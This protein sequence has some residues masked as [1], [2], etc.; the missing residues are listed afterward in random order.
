VA[1]ILIPAV[2][3]GA[4]SLIL[5][6]QIYP[7]VK[8]RARQITGYYN[9]TRAE[10]IKGDSIQQ[11]EV[12]LSNPGSDYFKKLTE[13]A[14]SENILQSDSISKNYRGKFNL[15]IPSLSLNN[16]PVQANVDSGNEKTYRSVL[17]SGLAHFQGTGLP[18]SD[19]NNNI[20][21][22][23]HSAG[24][25]YYSRTK[26]VAAAF[27]K[28]SEIKIGDSIVINMDGKEYKYRVVKTKIVKPDDSSII[29]GN[30]GKETL[31]LFTCYPNGNN[32]NRFVAVARPE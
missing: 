3:I 12:Y 32:S 29:N 1:R 27:S 19:I 25:D 28:L 23:G 15:S 30:K 13:N 4:G 5:F 21:V 26:D 14:M 11:K 18:V 2:L 10:L 17:T 22:Y 16:M 7:E 24:G 8:Q 6:K 9:P 20:V 31:T